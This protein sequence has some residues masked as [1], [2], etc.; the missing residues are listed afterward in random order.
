M[1]SGRLVDLSARRSARRDQ[2]GSNTGPDTGP[3]T[4]PWVDP[5]V[6]P[7]ADVRDDPR[8]D[9]DEQRDLLR[10]KVTD[11]LGPGGVLVVHD[12][13]LLQTGSWSKAGTAGVF[14]SYARGGRCRLVDRELYLQRVGIPADADYRRRPQLAMRMLTRA[15][16]AGVSPGWLTVGL[17][18]TDY[19]P[20]RSLLQIQGL[21]YLNEIPAQTMTARHLAL[22][23]SSDDVIVT[24]G[25]RW[26]RIRL[27]ESGRAGAG[28][29]LLARAG[30]LGP[31][32]SG[33]GDRDYHRCCGPEGTSLATLTQAVAAGRLA[34]AAL[35]GVRSSTDGQQGA[36]VYASGYPDWY[37]H[38]TRAMVTHA[39]SRWPAQQVR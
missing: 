39:G 37:R 36:A 5:A 23:A 13:E 32:G 17:G 25:A 11:S 18:Y 27:E 35:A 24:A 33:P 21:G 31:G 26:A 1:S 2:A 30:S 22:L 15:I 4:G 19:W 6:G 3:D 9:T 14:L 29:W 7:W 8:A 20:L 38:V 12:G 10:R 16:G 28:R 34:A